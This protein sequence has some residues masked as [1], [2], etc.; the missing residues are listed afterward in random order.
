MKSCYTRSQNT[1]L[2][3]FTSFFFFFT[4]VHSLSRVRL[5]DP[6]DCSTPGL[7]VHN[8]FPEFTPTHVHWVGDA[9]QPSHL[10]SS[11]SPA[12]NLSQHQGLSNEPVLHIRWP[13]YWHFSCTISPSN[14]YSGL[15]SFMMDW[16]SPCS[17]RDSQVSS[18]TPQFKSINYSALLKSYTK[19]AGILSR[20]F[21]FCIRELQLRF[22]EV[23][24]FLEWHW[25]PLLFLYFDFFFNSCLFFFFFLYKKANRLKMVHGV[26]KSQTRLSDFPFTF[27]FH[28]LEKEMATYSSVLAWRIPG[29]GEPGGLPS[30]GTHRVGHDWSD[31]AT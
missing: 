6:I 29:T 14:E 25:N 9:I 1:W 23:N 16:L 21:S 2:L 8:Q 24:T 27:H 17:P 11:P 13:K 5:C 19:H 4:S 20:M 28:A 18:P 30:M 12:F 31:L 22:Y 10:L 3:L 15:I 7:P 26:A